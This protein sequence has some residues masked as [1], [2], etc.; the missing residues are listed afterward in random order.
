MVNNMK[1]AFS[2]FGKMVEMI[3][4]SLNVIPEKKRKKKFEGGMR[5]KGNQYCPSVCRRNAFTPTVLP[6]FPVSRPGKLLSRAL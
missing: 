3:D 4:W 5:E 6:P 2:I 1:A